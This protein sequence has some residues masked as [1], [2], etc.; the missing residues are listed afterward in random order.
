MLVIL[1]VA[2][3]PESVLSARLGVTGATV[4]TVKLAPLAETVLPATSVTVTLGVTAPSLSSPPA[5]TS[6][7]QVPALLAVVV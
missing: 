5:R 2:L 1:S 6:T 3:K 4:S 7:D